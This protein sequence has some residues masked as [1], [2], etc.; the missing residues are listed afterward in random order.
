MLRL[1]LTKDAKKF[2]AR[3]PSKHKKQVARKIEEL[4]ANPQPHDSILM[5]NSTD[6]FR[7]TSGEYRIIYKFD[8]TALRISIIG[9]RN[10]GEAY[11]A[12]KRKN[13]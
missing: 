11:K 12:Y 6:T 10:D 13:R 7:N 5:K 3:L 1:D 8:D 4:R 9:K 2:L